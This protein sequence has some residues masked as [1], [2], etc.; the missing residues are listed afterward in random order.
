MWDVNYSCVNWLGWRIGWACAAANIAAA[1]RNIH[2]KL[3]DSAPAPFQE[4]ALIALTST[5]DY[6]E[7]LEKV[8]FHANCLWLMSFYPI[9]QPVIILTVLT[10]ERTMQKEET[11]F[12][13]YWKNMVSTLA[14]SHKVQS[15]CLLSCPSLGKFPTWASFYILNFCWSMR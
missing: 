13:S 15:L 9:Q 5:P 6:Y 7:S 4:A 11:S 10:L 2:V 14:S 12:F 1:I 3:T 8:R